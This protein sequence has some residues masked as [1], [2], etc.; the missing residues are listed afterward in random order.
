MSACQSCGA[1]C[2]C[3][4]V[5]FSVYEMD[6]AGGTV[7]SGMAHEVNGNTWRMEGTGLVPIR[8][9]ALGGTVGQRVG[10]SIYDL[11]PAP[12]HALEEGSEACH[13]ARAKLGLPAL[14]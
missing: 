12:C 1:C 5:E 7:P 14:S 10:C 2:A 4:R 6:F 3:F 9:V 13:R 11:R 8:C